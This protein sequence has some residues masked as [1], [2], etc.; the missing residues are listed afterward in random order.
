MLKDIYPIGIETLQPF[1]FDRV[2]YLMI[3]KTKTRIDNDYIVIEVHMNDA[4][5]HDYVF[6]I[7]QKGELLTHLQDKVWCTVAN[8]KEIQSTLWKHL[9]SL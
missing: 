5:W 2:F 1:Y 9:G 6:P 8:Y 7:A 3:F 4:Y